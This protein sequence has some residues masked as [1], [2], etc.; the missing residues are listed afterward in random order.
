MK[1]IFYKMIE[2]CEWVCPESLYEDVLNFLNE[3]N[4]IVPT[5]SI[6]TRFMNVRSENIDAVLRQL[7]IQGKIEKSIGLCGFPVKWMIVSDL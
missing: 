5:I 1:K 4:E 3:K 7:E 2:P 6:Y